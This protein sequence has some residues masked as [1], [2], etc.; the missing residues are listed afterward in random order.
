MGWDQL[1][2]REHNQGGQMS[3]KVE[4]LTQAII[5]DS[6][7]EGCSAQNRKKKQVMTR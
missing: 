2:R 3:I 4:E 6:V 1:V 5:K 7:E